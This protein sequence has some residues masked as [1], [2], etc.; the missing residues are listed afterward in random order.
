MCA[1]YRLVAAVGV[2]THA[3]LANSALLPGTLRLASYNV[4]FFSPYEGHS[5]KS[6]MKA[7]IREVNADVLALQEVPKRLASW[8][9]DT[10]R[11][12]YVRPHRSGCLNV[13]ASRVPLRDVHCE[14][15]AA[16]GDRT[17]IHGVLD[18]GAGPV[19]VVCTHLDV[20]DSSGA[21]RAAQAA[22]LEQAVSALPEANTIVLGDMNAVRREHYGPEHW[23][24]IERQD[25]LRGVEATPAFE[26]DPLFEAGYHDVLGE[27]GPQGTHCVTV[28]SIRRVDY[29]LLRPSWDLPIVNAFV[30]ST[31]ASDH[32]PIVVDVNIAAAPAPTPMPLTIP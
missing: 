13:L 7:A 30:H 11:Y 20:W 23:A 19:R 12:L 25:R 1:Q 18:T 5:G 3:A 2:A 15:Y 14:A 4:H 8:L 28:W 21:K 10:Y 27:L 6:A 17:Y 16:G 26:L 9:R 22:E 31:A 29:A 32:M 24:W